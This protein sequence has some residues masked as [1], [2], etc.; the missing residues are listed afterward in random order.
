MRG[1]RDPWRRSAPGP[2]R[3]GVG[4]GGAAGARDAAAATGRRGAAAPPGPPPPRRQLAKQMAGARWPG[5]PKT[6]RRD[7][8]AAIATARRVPAS[9][10]AR[11]RRK[12]RIL[13][14]PPGSGPLAPLPVA[15]QCS[16]SP[17]GAGGFV[18]GAGT[19]TGLVAPLRSGLALAA[20]PLPLAAK[21][22]FIV[23]AF[24]ER[25]VL[26]RMRWGWAP[27]ARVRG[28]CRGG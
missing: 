26:K 23:A 27:G 16:G 28:G 21:G 20:E 17:A 15:G 10:R 3:V 25:S 13:S 22:E 8:Q 12:P 7:Q 1:Q 24:L 4:V 2:S 19:S 6:L 9:P 5:G 18:G 11:A 14:E